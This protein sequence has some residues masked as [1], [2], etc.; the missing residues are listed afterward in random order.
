[1]PLDLSRVLDSV[2]TTCSGESPRI[3]GIAGKLL[4]KSGLLVMPLPLC[5]GGSGFLC[6]DLVLDR[7]G[8]CVSDFVAVSWGFVLGRGSCKK[9]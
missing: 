4:L 8:R 1:M 7:I 9:E 2:S 3:F 5:T 6:F